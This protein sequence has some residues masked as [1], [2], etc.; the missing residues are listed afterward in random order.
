MSNTGNEPKLE[1]I[2]IIG[3]AGRFPG[4]CSPAEFWRNLRCGIESITQF[5][6]EELEI[7]NA[8]AQA[9]EPN[10]VRAR[11]ILDGIDQFDP[12]FFGIYPQ[13][14]K[15]MDPQHRIFL[16]CCWE[17]IEDAGH[18]CSKK[19]TSVGV[20]AGCSPNSYFLTQVCADRNYALDYSA[21]YQVGQYTTML[22]TIAD[23]LATRVAYKLD[24]RGPAVTVLCACSTSLVAVCQACT[25]LLTYQCDVALSGGVSITLPQ[26][27]GYLYQ[28]GGMV[29]PDGHCRSFDE[30]AQGTVFGSGAGVVLLKRLADA[31]ADGDH[32]YG[33]IKGFA[34]NNDGSS[35][36]GFTAPSVDGQA[37]AIA[38]AQAI[39]GFEPD[40]ITYI[41]AHGTGTPLGDPIEVAALNQVFRASTER[42]AFCAIG[43]AKTNVGHLDVAAGVTGL[44]KTALSLHHR[45]LPPTLHFRKPNPKLNLEDSPFYVNSE[46]KKWESD[47][48]PLRAGVSAFGVGGT[49]AHVVLEEAP[50]SAN[51]SSTREHQLLV[52]SARSSNAL[53]EASSRLAGHLES[54]QNVALPDV[55][56][57]LATGR[58]A[59]HHR[60]A[61]ICRTPGEAVQL[62][63]NSGPSKDVFAGVAKE[64]QSVCFLFPG[65]GSQ[66][67][68]MGMGLYASE[69]VYREVVDQGAE[70]LQPLLA[71]DLRNILYAADSEEAKQQLDQTFFSQPAIFITEFALAKLWQS[72]GVQPSAMVGHSVG[73]FVAAC[74]ACVFSLEDALRLVAGRARLM[75]EVPR[76]AMLSVRLAEAEVL[77]LLNGHLSLAAVNGPRLSVVSGPTTSVTALKTLLDGKGIAA[78]TLRTSH[79]FHSSMM[80][81]VLQAFGEQVRTVQLHAPLMPYVSSATGDWI[82]PEEATNPDYWTSH[83]R[84]T[85]R[86]SDAI[87]KV[88]GLKSTVLLEV[89]AGAS[90]QTLARQHPA[91]PDI[92][93]EIYST[94]PESQAASEPAAILKALGAMWSVGVDV[95]WEGFFANENRRRTPLPTYPFERSRFWVDADDRNSGE[96]RDKDGIMQVQD[97]MSAEKSKVSSSMPEVNAG[98]ERPVQQLKNN[99]LILFEELSGLEPAAL[100]P[101]A[102]FL[103]LGFDSLF[104]TQVAQSVSSKFKVAITFRQ[105]LDELT[106]IDTLTSYLAGAI[107]DSAW[108]T[109]APNPAVTPEN[110]S[111]FSASTVVAAVERPVVIAEAPG[112]VDARPAGAFERIMKDQLAA[113]SQL[114][115]QQLACL[116]SE[117]TEK[118]PESSA[119]ALVAPSSAAVS[120]PNPVVAQGQPT[121][122]PEFKPFGPYKPA[123]RESTSEELTSMQKAYL[124]SLIERYNRKTA[125]SKEL[126]QKYR[127]VLADPRVASGFRSQWKDLVYPIVTNRSEGSKLWDIDGNEY[128]DLLNGFGPIALGH[129]P[130]FVKDAVRQ[131][132]EQGIEIGPQTPLAGE[133]AE[134]LCEITGMERATF[135]NTGSEAV[136]A[137]MRLART[138]TGRSKVVFFSGDYH[139]NFDEVLVKKI[140]STGKTRSLPIAPGIPVESVQNVIVLDYGSDEALAYIRENASD[141]AAVLVEPVQSRHPAVQPSAF[142]QEVRRLTAANGTALIFDEIVTG[143]RVHLG[144]AQAYY[145]IR[146]DLA[147]YGKVLGGGFPIGAIAGSRRFMDALD[148]GHWNYGDDSFPEVGVTFFAGT[149]VR[150]PLA[151]AAAKAV[152]THLKAAGPALQQTLSVRTS[153]LA[154]R[155]NQLFECFHIPAHAE[156]CGSVFY[157]SMPPTFRFGSLLYYHLRE[158]GIHIQEGFPCFLTTAHTNSEL[159]TVVA[160]FAASLN[161]MS[162]GGVLPGTPPARLSAQDVTVEVPITESQLEILVSAKLSSDANCS[163]NEAFSIHLAGTLDARSLQTSLDEIVARHDALRATF[164]LENK[165]IRILPRV[166]L[167]FEQIDLS[168]NPEPKSQMGVLIDADARVAFDLENGPLVRTKLMRLAPA[169]HVLLFTSHHIVCDGWSTNIIAEELGALYS[170]RVRGAQ[171]ELQTPLSFASYA[172][173]AHAEAQSDSAKAVEQYWLAQ[174]EQIPSLLDLPLDRPRPSVKCFSGSTARR[175]FTLAT[176][177]TV[178]RLGASQGC[179]LFVTLLAGFQTL[180]S[181]L[182]GQDDVVVGIPAAAQS[183]LNGTLVGHCVNFLPLRA[184]ISPQSSFAAVL[185][186]GRTSLLDAYDHQKYTFG[187]LVRKL[188][189]PRDPSR[190]PLI[191]VQFNLE[192][193]GKRLPF[194]ELTPKLDS[195]AKSFV[196]FDLFLNVVE[197]EEG[198]TLDCDY[199]TDLFDEETI[200]RWLDSYECLLLSAASNAALT[201]DELPLLNPAELAR[202][203]LAANRT[204]VSYPNER[205]IHELFEDHAAQNAARVALVCG[206]TSVSYG[207][208]NRRAGQLAAFLSKNGVGPNRL[209]AVLV[210]RS[211]EMVV[212]M[213]GILKAGGAYLPLDASYPKD[214]LDFILREAEPAVILTEEHLAPG[215][216]AP[217]ARIFCLDSEWS[218]LPQNPAAQVEIRP[219]PQD[220]AYVIYTSGSTG[221]PKGV[222]ISHRAVVNFLSSMLV[223]PSLV[224]ED[225]LLAVTTI[226]FDIA[227]LEIFLPLVAGARVV[228]ANRDEAGDGF[229]LAKLIGDHRIT[230]MQGTPSTWRLL[231]EAGWKPNPSLKM[232]CGGEALPRDLADELLTG[233]AELWN[234]YGPTE[235]TIWSA[236]S[237]VGQGRTPVTIGPPIANTYCYVLNGSLQPQPLGVPGELYIGGDGVARGYFKRPELTA[238]KF[239]LD[240]FRKGVNPAAKMYRTGDLVRAL[241]QGKFE[242]LGRL[243]NQVKIRGF[244]IELGEIES[245]LAAHEGILETVVTVHDERGTK[246]LVAYYTASQPVSG[247]EL[248][249]FLADRLPRYMVPVFFVLLEKLP[250]TPNGKID[251]KALPAVDSQATAISRRSRRNPKNEQ[252][253]QLL[254]ICEEVLMLDQI[255]TEDNLFELGADSIQIFR[256]VARANRAGLTL[257]ASAIFRTPTIEALSMHSAVEEAPKKSLRRGPIVPVSRERQILRAD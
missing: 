219:S 137:A 197:S 162:A 257:T 102:S 249:Q 19:A 77:P 63:R 198:L 159:D 192:R 171:P 108:Q 178:K 98:T 12:A 9:S 61:L 185:K 128:I 142:L 134:L 216:T 221:Q 13:E 93:Q 55:G 25:S 139:G 20:F 246:S 237:R 173:T 156:S 79:A 26:K 222:E 124:A 168:S 176:T 215:I 119:K 76:G 129:L 24:L 182:S 133:V 141:L 154:E 10:Y 195:C 39:A 44:I 109:I 100:D 67:L 190:L 172:R 31:V 244:R 191:E 66:Y 92:E 83:L 207:E 241:P 224:L 230:V 256:I 64:Q 113:M 170:A 28:E 233:D 208:L 181:R 239:R 114:I 229:A 127:A 38:T 91:P 49:N 147:T 60:R 151:L 57:T 54:D 18:D 225:R 65:Q 234:M 59:F 196:N 160:G 86:F 106:S 99:I 4:A 205:C 23:T 103:E 107:P 58:R 46:L 186:N 136:M 3:L 47:G 90:L 155:L 164:D 157:F 110:G 169:E 254:S 96:V 226:S 22:G 150:H 206:G 238:E 209:V 33:V 179:T 48:A 125:K 35:K 122:K 167:P 204:D 111:S 250:R 235:T 152:L 218:T 52:L 105:L 30:G 184:H 135:C 212:A 180:L 84:N 140:G 50:V 199:N 34:V 69:P 89:G 88:R 166:Q 188:R 74:L 200:L 112:L 7:R 242:F 236:V 51:V 214:R 11:S 231:L 253:K 1:G 132:L 144:G 149:F 97:A 243:D 72:W 94:L 121:E 116:Q 115:A 145:G 232:L 220:L 17:A 45:E 41:E 68:R 255:S 75:Q 251:R 163:F 203:V 120:S 117:R 27:R 53:A 143:F 21:A 177:Q 245:A 126:T 16:E 118:Q 62:L 138:V 165:A 80:D 104:L 36:V 240:P 223:T 146:A 123:Q 85:V 131:Q 213:L 252:E 202:Q 29:S 87:R 187:T 193:V 5:S 6:V 211:I 174:F 130:P 32:I 73:E 2:A 101:T 248:K 95:S 78:R 175:H 14:A 161:E 183:L 8:T 37:S 189:M 148:G 40:T 82:K 217:L 70:I 158:Q 15:L 194:Q 56:F 42:K 210:D 71:E 227:A 228:I 247:D 81:G 43:T 201:V 153:E